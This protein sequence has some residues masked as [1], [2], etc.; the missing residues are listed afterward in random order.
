MTTK[1]SFE[2]GIKIIGLIIAGFGVWKYFD[3]RAVEKETLSYERSLTYISRFNDKQFVTARQTLL[4]FWQQY[5]SVGEAIRENKITPN[6]YPMVITRIYGSSLNRNDI[7]GALFTMAA[8]FHEISHCRESSIC[9][10]EI[11]DEF[12]CDYSKRFSMAYAPF[13]KIISDEIGSKRLMDAP[14]QRLAAT[15][16]P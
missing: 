13:Y 6:S 16:T 9:N 12:F 4:G 14:M 3:E 1:D 11:L 7:D 5:P 10:Q 8:F 2:I 15:C